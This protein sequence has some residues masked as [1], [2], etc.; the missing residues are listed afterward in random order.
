VAAGVVITMSAGTATPLVVVGMGAVAGST[1][2]GA[3][4]LA[5]NALDDDLDPFDEVVANSVRGGLLGA[6]TASL[7]L[8]FSSV[9][10]ATTLPAALAAA[11]GV[12]SDA[13][14]ITAV[15]GVDILFPES[16]EDGIHS[17][18]GAISEVTGAVGAFKGA[19]NS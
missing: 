9:G 6:T 18:A 16:I 1:A 14:T 2:G 5:V 11:A 17:R 4:T 13:A 3:T 19:I 8:G 15:G 7:P 10:S 12:T